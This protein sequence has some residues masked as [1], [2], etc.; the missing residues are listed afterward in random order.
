MGQDSN[1][2]APPKRI[3]PSKE[4]LPL[5]PRPGS[6][7]DARVRGSSADPTR[8]EAGFDARFPAG[9]VGLSLV[10]L[11]GGS[12]GSAGAVPPQW[13]SWAQPRAPGLV[14][15][16]P[17][18]RLSHP[19]PRQAPA[20]L[21]PAARALA[22]FLPLHQPLCIWKPFP[23]LC[24]D[25]LP[26][27]RAVAAP[28][29]KAPRASSRPLPPRRAAQSTG[30]EDIPSK[31]GDADPWPAAPRSPAGPR[32]QPPAHSVQGETFRTRR[33]PQP[34]AAQGSPGSASTVLVTDQSVLLFMKL[35]FN[36]YH[37]ATLVSFLTSY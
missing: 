24:H 5:L 7:G 6:G 14:P 11:W 22:E 37:A 23:Q 28:L 12:S 19:T 8:L 20:A 32:T 35:P 31:P 17:R 3:F 21:L 1:N 2:K 18:P 16:S 9:K 36:N 33:G 29:P 34:S 4:S 30:D 13:Q 25:L 15:T 26:S 10:L 27:P